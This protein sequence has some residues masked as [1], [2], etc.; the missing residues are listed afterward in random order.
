[1]TA[2]EFEDSASNDVS[3]STASGTDRLSAHKDDGSGN[4]YE[5]TATARETSGNSG[6]DAA[7]V[8]E[9]GR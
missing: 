9:N 7:A 5:V 3:G 2:G 6:E 4:D 1:V 8:T